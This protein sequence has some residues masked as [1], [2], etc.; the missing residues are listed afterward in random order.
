MTLTEGFGTP[1]ALHGAEHSF[2]N[3]FELLTSSPG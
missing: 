2:I 3:F 1:E